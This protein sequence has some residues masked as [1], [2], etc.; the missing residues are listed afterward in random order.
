[1]DMSLQEKS[2][3]VSLLSTVGVFGYY[4]YNIILL[5]GL[6]EAEALS[7]ALA[8]SVKTISLVVIIEILFQSLLAASN[9]R[10]AALGNDERDK[11]FKD[12]SSSI[13]YTVLVT[14]VFLTLGRIVMLEY[15]PS[16]TESDSSLQIPL[17]TGHILLLSFILAEVSRFAALIYF[18]R[19]GN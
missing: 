9:H 1:M 19:R 10:E 3:W 13:A 6:P 5:A 15:N 11:L 16:L 14:G 7:I 8:I 18:Y 2:T 4:F 12:K 17:L